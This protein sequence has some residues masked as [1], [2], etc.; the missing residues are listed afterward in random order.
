MA[1]NN[2]VDKQIIGGVEYDIHDSGA[3]DDLSSLTGRVV[4]LEEAV[5]LLNG[6]DVLIVADHT[7][8]VDPD[9]TKIYRE[10]G[11]NSYTDWMYDGQWKDIATYSFPGID[12][13]PTSVSNNCVKSGGIYYA[14]KDAE[15]KILYTYTG[16]TSRNG[17]AW[18]FNDFKP[19][20]GESYYVKLVS[21]DIGSL[22]IGSNT[23]CSLQ[24]YNEWHLVTIPNNISETEN[25]FVF[26]SSKSIASVL[27]IADEKGVIS[28]L[29]TKLDVDKDANYLGIVDSGLTSVYHPTKQGTTVIDNGYIIEPGTTG[30]YMG[31]YY[32]GLQELFNN[33]LGKTIEFSLVYKVT[34][35]DAN[36]YYYP[37]RIVYKNTSATGTINSIKNEVI[38]DYLVFRFTWQ[39]P[40]QVVSI[41]SDILYTSTSAVNNSYPVTFVCVSLLYRL[42]ETIQEGNPNALVK[43]G[44]TDAIEAIVQ[45]LGWNYEQEIE[46]LTQDVSGLT[47]TVNSHTGQINLLDAEVDS[48][49][50][51]VDEI[52]ED[53]TTPVSTFSSE[54]SLGSWFYSKSTGNITKS[55]YNRH[56]S[57]VAVTPGQYIE[58]SCRGYEDT[59]SG[60]CSC[61][62]FDNTTNTSD[63]SDLTGYLSYVPSPN[64]EATVKAKVPVGAAYV[65]VSNFGSPFTATLEN[66]QTVAKSE[67]KQI[68]TVIITANRD[69]NSGAD[70]VGLTAISDAINSIT[71]ASYSKRYV[72]KVKGVFVFTDPLIVP[73][74]GGGEYSII[75]MKDYV[76]IEGDGANKSVLI[77]DFPANSTF[78]SGKAYSDYQPI[79]M[80]YG[81]KVSNIR[82]IG[83]NCRYAFHIETT[84]NADCYDKEI[85]IDNCVVEYLGHPDY[86]GS[87]GDCLGTGISSGQTWNIKNSV[88]R[89]YN[90]KSFAMHT[91]LQLFDRP[92]FVNFS[93]C[94]FEGNISLHNYQVENNTFVNFEN[95]TFGQGRIGMINYAVYNNR[96]TAVHGDYTTI[97]V[98]GNSLKALF[99]VQGNL[100][101]G[102]DLKGAVLR[103][104]SLSTGTTSVVRFN[105]N[106]SAFTSIIGDGVSANGNKTNYGWDTNYGYVY[107]D[108]GVGLS[109]VAFGTLD[110]DENASNNVSLGKLLGNCSS[111]NKT[112]G[113][114]IDGVDYSIVFDE[115]YTSKDNAYVLST[116]NTV[117]GAKGIADIFSPIILY[118]P[119]INGLQNVM[120]DDTGSIHRGMGVIYTRYGVKKAKNSDNRIDGIA[121]DDMANGQMGRI[122]TMGYI[123]S[124]S[125]RNAQYSSSYNT[126]LDNASSQVYSNKSCGISVTD[127]GVFDI[128]AT[129]KLIREVHAPLNVEGVDFCAW[130]IIR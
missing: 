75:Y 111:T 45:K 3:R 34:G 104:K 71:D 59:N 101:R 122:I 7:A 119:N 52:T 36:K 28:E 113:V 1:G 130:E 96:T 50:N 32:G 97:F 18:S 38:G 115:N 127:D 93:N 24:D 106:S 17:R 49:S 108:G 95:C 35:Q 83:K 66:S 62:F 20:V 129:P 30:I 9:T 99:G 39:V 64:G 105:H 42:S 68:E 27:T 109:G 73:M 65:V 8:V 90:Y 91:P 25:L 77:M 128:N 61:V 98:N 12:D 72:I 6:N 88:F 112:L 43:N 13:D 103:I 53:I 89:W 40:S 82:V 10:Q 121:L 56:S 33:N 44:F 86:V 47:T 54:D 26:P 22:G 81:H 58:Y 110:V 114:S 74:E 116:I 23:L 118:Y 92:A 102:A 117:I 85:T 107:R 76:D 29:N 31:Y 11:T 63:W 123:Y 2:Y 48:I 14:I 60:I 79:Y 87:Y 57:K 78:H 19:Q 100:N 84:G 124:Q 15:S 120:C 80:R 5:P 126:T 16:T 4:D 51:I 21:G 69:E 55:N 37:T 125:Y 41:G 46:E 94:I 70:F 67:P